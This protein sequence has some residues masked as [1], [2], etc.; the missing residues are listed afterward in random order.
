MKSSKVVS[1]FFWS[2]IRIKVIVVKLLNHSLLCRPIMNYFILFSVIVLFSGVRAE[3]EVHGAVDILTKIFRQFLRS[4]PK[5][6]QIGDGVHLLNTRSDNDA[7]AIADDGTV[8]G[9]LE[10]YLETHELRIRLAELMP[11][12]G[13][14][15]SF[16][17][18]VNEIYGFGNESELIGYHK[19]M[20]LLMFIIFTLRTYVITLSF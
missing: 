13:F 2:N 19:V 9:V 11:G 8:M 17:S 18:T 12:E 15:R 4:Q 7:R 6:F 10:N 3:S 20:T 16:K 5:D 14:G 1:A